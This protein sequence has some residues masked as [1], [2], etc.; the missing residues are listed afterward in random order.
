[1]INLWYRSRYFSFKMCVG[2]TKQIKACIYACAKIRRI[3]TGAKP[4]DAK[5]A[6]L[7]ADL[8]TQNRM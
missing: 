2:I 8:N 1:M 4:R 7:S 5:L 3:L 6:G